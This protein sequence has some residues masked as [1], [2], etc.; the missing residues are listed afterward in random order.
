MLFNAENVFPSPSPKVTA[1]FIAR[2]VPTEAPI[3]LLQTRGA[4]PI[5][6]LI[7]SPSA[8][9]SRASLWLNCGR[10]ASGSAVRRGAREVRRS[11]VTQPCVIHHRVRK[12]RGL[13]WIE[14]RGG[15]GHTRN[16]AEIDARTLYPEDSAN[17]VQQGYTCTS[18]EARHRPGPGLDT[19]TLDLLLFYSYSVGDE[20][21][22]QT[23]YF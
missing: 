17:D 21:S 12:P 11:P 19:W 7:L 10:R 15:K 22:C 1:H 5:T 20:W 9:K 4:R 8:M 3:D 23:L 13:R 18:W 6:W 16:K 14:E 2:G